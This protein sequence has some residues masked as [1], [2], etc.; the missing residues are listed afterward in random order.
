[1]RVWNMAPAMPCR[2]TSSSPLQLKLERAFAAGY[3]LTGAEED[4]YILTVDE[5]EP[6][7]ED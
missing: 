2:S 7:L 6:G 4:T 3:R 5:G 1:M